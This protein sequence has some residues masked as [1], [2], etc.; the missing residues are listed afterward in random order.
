M[1][2]P[3]LELTPLG[4]LSDLES[5]D[6]QGTIQASFLLLNIQLTDSGFLL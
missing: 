5:H 3:T 4:S 2:A 1:N 6:L